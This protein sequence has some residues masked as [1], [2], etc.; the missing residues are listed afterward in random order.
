MTLHFGK[1]TQTLP[2]TNL[3]KT[4]PVDSLSSLLMVVTE[5]RSQGC[6]PTGA[7]QSSTNT[8]TVTSGTATPE[9]FS[10]SSTI[11]H[12]AIH[13]I[14]HAPVKND[15]RAWSTNTSL[16]L[17]ASAAMIAGLAGSIQNPAVQEME[18]DLSATSSQFSL[19]I[20]MFVLIQGLVPLVW[21][22]VS[23]VKG[24]KVVYI[25]SLSLFTLGT[26]VV[27]LSRN[28]N[29][30][31]GFRC[32][33]AAGSSAVMS[34]GAATLADIFEPEVRGTKMGIFYIAPLLGPAIGPIFGGVLTSAWNWRAIFWFLAIVSGSILLAFVL[35]F[36]DT[37][38]FERSLTYQSLLSQRLRQHARSSPMRNGL[39]KTEETPPELNKTV[40]L[41]IMDVNPF[42][43]AIKVLQRKNNNV[44]LFTSGLLFA[45]AFLVPYTSARTL[46][47]FYDYSPLK[48]GLVTLCYGA[49]NVAGSLLGGRWSDRSLARLMT[50]DGKARNPEM[51]L[52]STILGVCLLPPCSI[53]LGWV[54]KKHLH[55]STICVFLF[56]CGF[57][58][59]WIYTSTLAYIVDANSGRS[60]TAAAAN[61]AFRGIFAFA[62]TELAVPIQD[63]LGDGWTYTILGGFMA[64]SGSLVLLVCWKG[65]QWRQEAETR[66]AAAQK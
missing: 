65:A 8:P 63:G 1:T 45:F 44:I 43:P 17:V 58:N 3:S 11:V 40:K 30:V 4:W 33:Q 42:K 35:F 28:I 18:D 16:A 14:E 2:L 60:S 49:G 29:L 54:C 37:F 38:R 25:V 59:V 57:F 23:E 27:A 61:S 7:L 5:S 9:P 53:A 13:D 24:R 41:S 15:P 51:R 50:E 46:A 26:I 39:E 32:L 10:V 6:L 12:S 55:V 62:A 56:F 22:A 34:I 20:A 21:S 36:H 64:L 48:I 52:R 19:S 66:E 47:I 31:I